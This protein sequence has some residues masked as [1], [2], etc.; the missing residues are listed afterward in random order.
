MKVNPL[1]HRAASVLKAAGF[2]DSA[3]DGRIALIAIHSGVATNPTHRAQL[4]RLLDKL[5]DTVG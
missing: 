1:V 2:T 3:E 4:H 5:I